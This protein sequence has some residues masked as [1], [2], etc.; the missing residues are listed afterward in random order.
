MVEH[1]GVRGG[2]DDYDHGTFLKF[3]NRHKVIHA[4]TYLQYIGYLLVVISE[5]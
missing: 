4:M 3:R 2:W 1:G 5:F